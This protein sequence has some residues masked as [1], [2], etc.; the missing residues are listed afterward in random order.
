[1]MRNVYLNFLIVLKT[2]QHLF[3]GR[4]WT[5]ICMCTELATQSHSQVPKTTPQVDV[6]NGSASE[7]YVGPII[8]RNLEI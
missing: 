2:H 3:R 4:K 1:M 8:P 5:T 7:H 6:H